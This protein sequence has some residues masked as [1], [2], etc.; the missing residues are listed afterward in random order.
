MLRILTTVYGSRAWNLGHCPPSQSETHI[1]FSDAAW[2]GGEPTPVDPSERA[3]LTLL[4]SQAVATRRQRQIQP[5][6]NSP[7]SSR[8]VWDKMS[9]HDNGFG[10]DLFD[11]SHFTTARKLDLDAGWLLPVFD[12]DRCVVSFHGWSLFAGFDSDC[13]VGSF[14]DRHYCRS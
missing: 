12:S 6:Q 14:Y 10:L 3:G 11:D 5:N 8:T 2:K 1:A 4:L 13:C 7:C 9:Q